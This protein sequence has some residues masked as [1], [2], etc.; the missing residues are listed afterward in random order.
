VLYG[1][2]CPWCVAGIFNA[3]QGG[4][5]PIVSAAPHHYMDNGYNSALTL[6]ASYMNHTRIASKLDAFK[7]PVSWL[8][9]NRPKIPLHLAEVNSNTFS[10]GNE[11]QLGV[12]GSCLW[13]VDYMMYGMT[14]NIKRMNVQQSTGFS[15]TS[16]RGVD[17]FGKPAAVLPPYY[18]HPFVAD[19]IGNSGNIRVLDLKLGLDQLSAYAI[20]NTATNRVSKIVLINLREWSSTSSSS[21]PSRSVTI[22]VNN[23]SYGGTVRIEKL[24]APGAEIRDAGSISWKGQSWTRASNGLPISTSSTTQ[25]TRASGGRFTV[26]VKASEALLLTLG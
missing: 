19:V 2:N 15:Y 5:P 23:A 3:G 1:N 24:T 20:Y 18:A 26:E 6:Q 12:F 7:A 16:W 13:L 9:A 25:N 21:R 4:N 10:T 11:G 17:Y 14:L 22:N 8:K